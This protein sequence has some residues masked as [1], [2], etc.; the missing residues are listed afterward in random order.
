MGIWNDIQKSGLK[1]TKELTQKDFRDFMV[2]LQ[3]QAAKDT[4]E[5]QWYVHTGEGG[6]KMINDAMQTQVYIKLM[7]DLNFSREERKRLGEMIKSPDPENFQIAKILID[8]KLA[9]TKEIREYGNSK[10]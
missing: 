6:M 2:D 5:R 9:E 7:K 3:V 10:K 8:N 4:K 1:P